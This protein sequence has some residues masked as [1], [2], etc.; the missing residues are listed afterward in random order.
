M[1]Q[2]KSGLLIAGGTLIAV[3]IV[4]GAVVG[5]RESSHQQV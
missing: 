1:V 2:V 3:A 5:T 4:I